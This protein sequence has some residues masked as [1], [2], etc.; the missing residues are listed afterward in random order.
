MHGRLDKIGYGR[1]E[2]FWPS[3]CQV[4]LS[5]S[6]KFN[7]NWERVWRLDDLAGFWEG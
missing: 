1:I 6:L 5:K 3:G 4:T 2:T 7:L